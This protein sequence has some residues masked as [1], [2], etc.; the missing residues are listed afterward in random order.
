MA[1]GSISHTI[2]LKSFRRSRPYRANTYLHNTIRIGSTSA[3]NVAD[4]GLDL[5]DIDAANFFTG[6]IFKTE[7]SILV[8]RNAQSGFAGPADYAQVRISTIWMWEPQV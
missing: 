7:G 5:V 1:G 3:I 8:S 4:N 2:P 6:A